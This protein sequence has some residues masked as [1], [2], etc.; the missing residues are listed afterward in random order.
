MTNPILQ[1]NQNR[2]SFG[3]SSSNGVHNYSGSGNKRKIDYCWS[4]N[5]GNKCKFG[6]KCKFIERCSYCDDPSHGVVNC[7]KLERKEKDNLPR[8]GSFKCKNRSK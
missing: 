8:N 5:K 6:K 1:N 3:G 2:R 7:N 4:F